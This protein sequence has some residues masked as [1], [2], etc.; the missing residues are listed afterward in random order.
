MFIKRFISS[1]TVA[2]EVKNVTYRNSRVVV[3]KSEQLTALP[4]EARIDFTREAIRFKT[5]DAALAHA[6]SA[7]DASREALA[8]EHAAVGASFA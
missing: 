1:D 7:I 6:M 5:A 3:L 8:Q 4:F 2:V